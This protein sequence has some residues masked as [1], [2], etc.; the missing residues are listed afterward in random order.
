[1][2]ESAECV[3]TFP[4]VGG[5]FGV[6]LLATKLNGLL[7]RTEILP[8]HIGRWIDCRH[9][10]IRIR[11]ASAADGKVAALSIGSAASVAANGSAGSVIGGGN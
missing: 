6:G 3:I 5:I 7:S 8:W 2:S 1:M 9:T 10:A 4:V 11:F